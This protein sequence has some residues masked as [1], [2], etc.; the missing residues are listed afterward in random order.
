ME[1]D[2][3]SETLCSLEYLTMGKV[4]NPSNPEFGGT[5]CLHGNEPWRI[6]YKSGEL[7]VRFEVLSVLNITEY[8]LLG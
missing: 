3:I 8:D 6:C 2:L 7:F 5:F 1:T 4:Q